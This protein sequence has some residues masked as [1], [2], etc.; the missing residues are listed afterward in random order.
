MFNRWGVEIKRGRW[1][2]GKAGRNGTDYFSGTVAGIDSRSDFARAYGSQV[3]VKVGPQAGDTITVG[4]DSIS[5]SLGRMEV[6][7]GGVVTQNPL[8]RVK[9]KSPSQR[10]KAAPDARLLKRRKTTQ[11]APPG[12]YANPTPR[13]ES[14]TQPSQ[15]EHFNPKTGKMTTRPSKRLQTRRALTHNDAPPG[16]WA[17]PLTPAQEAKFKTVYAVHLP[18][19]PAHNAIAFFTKKSD[20]VDAARDTADRIGKPLAVSPVSQYVS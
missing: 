19:Q 3:T 9:V 20:A 4:A 6:G 5:Q 8:T 2:E 18:S 14:P 11:K 16:V 1:V 17:N 13:L 12:F 10:T 15:R 7:R